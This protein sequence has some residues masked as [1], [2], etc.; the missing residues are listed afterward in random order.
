MNSANRRGGEHEPC[1]P[2]LAGQHPARQPP[3]RPAADN[4]DI[5]TTAIATKVS[6]TTQ[7]AGASD[8]LPQAGIAATGVRGSMRVMRHST[9]FDCFITSK[10]PSMLLLSCHQY[11]DFVLEHDCFCTT[12]LQHPGGLGLCG[13]EILQE[14]AAAPAACFLLSSTCVHRLRVPA[15]CTRSHA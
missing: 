10:P 13:S 11:E 15:G 1:Q 6:A 7:P 4:G 9:P 8:T 12:E 2:E 14:A 3:N 5:H